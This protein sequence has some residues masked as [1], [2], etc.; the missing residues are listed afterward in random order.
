MVI[1][2]PFGRASGGFQNTHGSDWDEIG[3]AMQGLDQ[4]RNHVA[5]SETAPDWLTL[6]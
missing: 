3:F 5:P 4:S 2:I 1:R 6:L